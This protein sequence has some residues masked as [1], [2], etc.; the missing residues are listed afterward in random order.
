M[1]NYILLSITTT[2]STPKR[3]IPNVIQSN[4]FSK[5]A[6]SFAAKAFAKSNVKITAKMKIQN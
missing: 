6:L 2:D 4:S 1:N 5:A 3:D